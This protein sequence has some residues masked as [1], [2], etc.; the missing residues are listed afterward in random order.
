MSQFSPNAAQAASQPQ[1]VD[2]DF[3]DFTPLIK[4]LQDMAAS[5]QCFCQA[6]AAHPNAVQA[7]TAAAD[8][9]AAFGAA[10]GSA[11]KPAATRNMP[12]PEV[13]AYHLP[14]FIVAEEREL[15]ALYEAGDW[16]ELFCMAHERLYATAVLLRHFPAEEELDG[17]ALQL[18][19][20]NLL[21]PLK[22]LS[23]LC[24]LVADF[25]TMAELEAE[26]SQAM[27]P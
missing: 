12:P 14:G 27:R 13:R 26:E 25:R 22:M 16:Q 20:G 7:A 3:P 5:L 24:S 6:W 2:T 15:L 17:V 4:Q 18:I 1:F 8:G 11:S 21:A 23:R 19:A 9:E 10:G